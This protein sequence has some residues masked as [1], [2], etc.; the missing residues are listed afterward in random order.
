MLPLGEM[1]PPQEV[2]DLVAYLASG[3]VR[4]L[5]GATIDINGA[6]NIR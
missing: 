5:S 3:G 6:A 4:H 1:V 2:A